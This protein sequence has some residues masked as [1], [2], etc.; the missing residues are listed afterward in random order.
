MITRERLARFALADLLT[1]MP[2]QQVY[3]SSHPFWEHVGFWLEELSQAQDYAHY[4]AYVGCFAARVHAI[5]KMPLNLAAAFLRSRAEEVKAKAK[6]SAH[7][8][9]QEDQP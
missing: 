3:C 5:N 4:E 8:S 1:A 9:S 6:K 7:H 2:R